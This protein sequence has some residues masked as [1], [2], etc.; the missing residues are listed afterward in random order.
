MKI[1][2]IRKRP[3]REVVSIKTSTGTLVADGLAHHNCYNCNINKSGNWPSYQENMIK[4]HGQ[5]VVDDILSRRHTVEKW[6]TKDYEEKI[7]EYKDKLKE[8]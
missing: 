2:A 4:K 1:K 6:T 7:Q 3:P 8:L 5:E